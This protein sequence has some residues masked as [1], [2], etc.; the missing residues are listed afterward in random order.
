VSASRTA[1]VQI[2]P[3]PR[4]LFADILKT[5]EVETDICL[6]SGDYWWAH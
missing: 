6:F 1:H 5:T 4:T 2:R 3:I